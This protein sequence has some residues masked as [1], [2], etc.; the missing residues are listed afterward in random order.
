[1][2]LYIA[3]TYSIQGLLC[4]AITHADCKCYKKLEVRSWNHDSFKTKKI[5]W[6]ELSLDVIFSM[7]IPGYYL[8]SISLILE[9]SPLCNSLYHLFV[10]L[11]TDE[12][13][14]SKTLKNSTFLSRP[15][16]FNFAIIFFIY[17]FCKYLILWFIHF[18]TFGSYLFSLFWKKRVKIEPK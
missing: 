9:L 14:Y 13:T 11:E 5:L 2:D 17:I 12:R 16:V 6:E 3:K 7:L 1:M 15:S 18:N 8:I 10:V 4:A